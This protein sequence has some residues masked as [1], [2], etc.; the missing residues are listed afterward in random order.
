MKQPKRLSIFVYLGHVFF[1]AFLVIMPFRTGKVLAASVPAFVRSS[2][3]V[4]YSGTTL[5]FSMP[6]NVTNGD[7][8]A[9][10]FQMAAQG[11]VSYATV[12]Q[13]VVN[14]SP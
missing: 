13:V 8:L 14:W 5:N 12:N 10:G 2:T 3:G 9:A 4:S 11:S 7:I 6:N 1:L